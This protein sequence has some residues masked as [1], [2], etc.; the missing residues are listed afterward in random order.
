ML[1]DDWTPVVERLPDDDKMVLMALVD[2]E[3]WLGFR[4]GGIWRDTTA[5]PIA[6]EQV[7]DWMDL[8]AAPTRPNEITSQGNHA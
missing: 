4:D 8:P 2:G 5:L 3:V 6:D 1:I 7:T